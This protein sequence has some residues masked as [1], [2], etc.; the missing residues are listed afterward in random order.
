MEFE[1]L[2]EEDLEGEEIKLDI[3]EEAFERAYC[4]KC[5]KIMKEVRTD[6][7]LPGGEYTLHLIAS[8]C[9][10]CGKE[11]LSGNQVEKF[12]E[13]LSLMDAIKDKTKIKF[14]RAINH[15]GK[16][17]FVRFPKEIT[18]N[19]T[20]NMTTEIMP[21]KNNEILIHVHK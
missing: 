13:M 5:N 19:W 14:E 6:F 10:R 17:F 20:P 9:T 11:S 2:K 8:K 21:I 18:K 16:S 3:A 4:L 12:Q 7:E 1:Q 15:D